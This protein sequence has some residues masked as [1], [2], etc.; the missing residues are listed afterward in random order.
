[1]AP[2]LAAALAA[3]GR[4][5]G[6]RNEAALEAMRKELAE[7]R[8]HPERWKRVMNHHFGGRHHIGDGC[9][10]RLRGSRSTE[11]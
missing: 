5:W 9:Y 3:R 1:M 2:A 8:R 11:Y 4:V 7:L 6:D 10:S